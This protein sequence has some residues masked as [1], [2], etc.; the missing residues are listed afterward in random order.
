VCFGCLAAL[1]N[2][3]DFFESKIDCNNNFNNLI[4]L[5][6]DSLLSKI[7][8]NQFLPFTIPGSLIS[9]ELYDSVNG[10][11]CGYKYFE[12]LLFFYKIA[13]RISISSF[14]FSDTV[15][16]IWRDYSGVSNV[17][18]TSKESIKKKIELINDNIKY[19]RYLL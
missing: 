16:Y 8:V 18:L 14:G 1:K 5:N 7:V 9:R 15:N 2:N 10:F 12:D 19:Y 4:H 3:G 6:E 17:K 11:D 13:K